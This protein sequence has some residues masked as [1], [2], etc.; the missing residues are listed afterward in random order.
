MLVVPLQALPNQTLYTSLGGQNCTINVFQ[1]AYG[2]FLDL[3]V[4]STLIVSCVICL[5]ANL[6]VRSA[7]LG[8]DGDLAFVDTQ[9]DADPVYT[10]FGPG[11]RYQLLYLTTSDVA[12]LLPEGVE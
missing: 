3:Y 11:A 5:N 6:I 1:Y 2:L 7:Y 12:A 9:G 8:F 10:G 4:G